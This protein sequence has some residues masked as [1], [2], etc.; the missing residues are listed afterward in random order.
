MK[1]P[2]VLSPVILCVDDHERGLEVR[3]ML[4]EHAGY[5]VLTATDESR[6]LQLFRSHVVDGHGQVIALHPHL[7][8]WK[9]GLPELCNQF[10][11][12]KSTPRGTV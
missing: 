2:S 1:R 8:Y 11:G 7:A 9:R 5:R 12:G 10:L 4:L 6:A 3:Q